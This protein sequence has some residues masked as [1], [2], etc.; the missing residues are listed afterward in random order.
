M[1]YQY[2]ARVM[3]ACASFPFGDKVYR[4][5]QKRFGRLDANPMNRLL[6]QMEMARWILNHGGIVEGHTFLEVGTGHKPVVPIG[7][8]LSGAAGV[9]TVDL[10]SRLDYDLTRQALS[11]IANNREV[12]ETLFCEVIDSTILRERLTMVERLQSEPKR[13]LVEANIQYQAPSDAAQTG[14]PDNSVEF[15]FSVTTVEHISQRV[16]ESI[17]VEAKRI[18]TD[19][20]LAIHF[21]DLSDHFQHQDHSITKINFLRFSEDQWLQLAG[22]QFAYCN[23][24]RVSDHLALFRQTGFSVVHSEEAMDEE[25]LDVLRSGFPL[26]SSFR[27]YEEKDLCTTTL[28]VMLTS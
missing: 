7:F 27:I 23:R 5:M 24:L 3:K 28:R 15:H 22:N 12:M 4:L 1:R 25:S 13:F 16:I 19:D 26:D 10:N 6:I 14:L 8:F 17:F 20:G 18:L 2:K 21:I 9:I 11:W